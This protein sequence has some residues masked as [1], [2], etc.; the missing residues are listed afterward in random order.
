MIIIVGISPFHQGF[1]NSG[2][3]RFETATSLSM[4]F[5]RVNYYYYICYSSILQI[6]KLIVNLI[7]S[8]KLLKL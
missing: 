4:R 5:F 3:H 1:H 6:F 8:T 7:L 2:D